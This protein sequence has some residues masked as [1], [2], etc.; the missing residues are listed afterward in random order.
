MTVCD[1]V[2]DRDRRPPRRVHLRAHG[3]A[4]GG[5]EFVRGGAR[6]RHRGVGEHIVRVLIDEVVGRAR[7]HCRV[8][9][10]V[11]SGWVCGRVGRWVRGGVGSRVSG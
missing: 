10:R 9:V 1:R 8:R 11:T 6:T 4:G 5:G 2:H 7:Y 3:E